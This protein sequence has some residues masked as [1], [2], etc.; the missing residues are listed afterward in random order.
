M[1]A[2]DS[3]GL[4]YSL[5][6]HLADVPDVPGE[7][8]YLASLLPLSPPSALDCQRKGTGQICSRV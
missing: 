7:N 6:L 1:L 5:V 3:I 8:Q 4:V 2:A